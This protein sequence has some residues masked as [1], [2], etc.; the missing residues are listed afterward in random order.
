MQINYNCFFVRRQ[1]FTSAAHC[2]IIFK[3]GD[4]N[5]DKIIIKDLKLFAYHGVN[6]EEK[7]NGQN[8]ILDILC[9]LDFSKA[10]ESD[11]LNDT[12]SY[13]KVLK[14]ARAAFTENKY[15]LLERAAQVVADAVFAGYPQ[16]MT[17]EITLKKPEAPIK[18]DFGYVGVTL[19]RERK[20]G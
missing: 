8:F 16:I 6:P 12:V 11:D 5:T 14:T 3:K 13:A 20:N 17:I 18:A 7:E 9:G 1:V 10:C 4:D 2:D 19:Y 15:D